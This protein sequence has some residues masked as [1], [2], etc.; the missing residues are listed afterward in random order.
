MP[1]PVFQPGASDDGKR[2]DAAMLRHWPTL[3]S[4]PSDVARCDSEPVLLLT[5]LMM[6]GIAA[7]PA[8]RVSGGLKD[9]GEEIYPR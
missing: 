6:S 5:Q 7:Y 9:V 4:I 8:R 1:K 3:L 2:K